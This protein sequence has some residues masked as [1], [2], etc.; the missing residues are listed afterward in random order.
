MRNARHG[1]GTCRMKNSRAGRGKVNK[2]E[3]QNSEFGR[4]TAIKRD[5]T[6]KTAHWICQCKCGTIRSV[7]Q[8]AL[9]HGRSKSCGCLQKE[10]LAS[11]RTT[12]KRK[13]KRL[14]KTW[15]DMIQR[16][17]NPNN[18]SYSR[19][20][21]REISV[22]EE[23]RQSFESFRD[24]ALSSGYSDELTIDRIDNNKS[25]TPD[26]CRWT[27]RLRQS[28]NR[29]NTIF[30]TLN[31]ETYHLQ[32]WSRRTGIPPETLRRRY[33]RGISAEKILAK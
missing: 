13:P 29:R 4:W 10:D 6:R 27:T 19:Y 15:S 31:G 20:G 3:M 30:V 33:L 17:T 24:W 8:A 7:E 28:I 12:H 2:V 22:C 16:T 5:E 1:K 26:N 9:K 32:E 25:Y 11:R 14:Y 18:S 23:W 21:G